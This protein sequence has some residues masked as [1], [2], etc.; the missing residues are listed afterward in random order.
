M[1]WIGILT[2]L[3]LIFSCVAKGGQII[4]SDDKWKENHPKKH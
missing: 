3:G 4:T 1:T 2:L